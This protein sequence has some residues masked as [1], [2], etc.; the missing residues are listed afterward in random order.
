MS[1]YLQCPTCGN[2]P[3]NEVKFCYRDGSRLVSKR[4]ICSCGSAVNLAFDKF[5]ENCGKAASEAV[6]TVVEA[7]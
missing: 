7:E 3:I 4:A 1:T 6:V 5:C 2:T